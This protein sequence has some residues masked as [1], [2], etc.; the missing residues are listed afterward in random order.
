MLLSLL[1]DGRFSL[2]NQN[3]AQV[4]AFR[5]ALLPCPVLLDSALFCCTHLGHLA[6]LIQ[7]SPLVHSTLVRVQFYQ[8]E[9]S[10]GQ[11]WSDGPL[12]F[13][14]SYQTPV[15]L[16][17]L[18]VLLVI[19]RSAAIHFYRPEHCTCLIFLDGS[20]IGQHSSLLP[21]EWNLHRKLLEM[22]RKMCFLEPSP[23]GIFLKAA[24][25]ARKLQKQYWE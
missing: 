8:T 14:Q 3:S 19:A 21:L 9:F 16:G 25:I 12:A 5:T 22:L 20:F 2:S 24:G 13:V 11:I 7:L 6:A 23:K 1:L 17:L 18:W 4:Q 15:Y 10:L